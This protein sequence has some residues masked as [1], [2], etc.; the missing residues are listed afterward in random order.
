M[1]TTGYA[2]SYGRWQITNT[3]SSAAAVFPFSPGE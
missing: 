1:Q 3:S 2:G